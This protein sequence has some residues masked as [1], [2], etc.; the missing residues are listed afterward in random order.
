M[1]AM[2]GN[3]VECKHP[4]DVFERNAVG[5][6]EGCPAGVVDEH[7]DKPEPFA[8]PSNGRDAL[9]WVR[10]VE[11]MEGDAVIAEFIDQ[12]LKPIDGPCVRKDLCAAR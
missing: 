9:R 12:R 11:G 6:A 8:A 4:I 5:R 2:G 3:Q 7:V 1:R 10:G